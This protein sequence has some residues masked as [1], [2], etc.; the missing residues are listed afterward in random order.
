M[1]VAVE[2]C[3]LTFDRPRPSA[4]KKVYQFPAAMRERE[5]GAYWKCFQ[6]GH[7][8]KV[9]GIKLFYH[10]IPVY[11]SALKSCVIKSRAN[12]SIYI[13]INIYI[14]FNIYFRTTFWPADMINPLKPIQQIKLKR[15]V[16][17]KRQV[18]EDETKFP[19][20]NCESF[21]R[22]RKLQPKPRT[23]HRP[24]LCAQQ[25]CQI[26]AR[27]RGK[28]RQKAGGKFPCTY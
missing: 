27:I 24:G 13:Y 23:F 14:M 18:A 28:R 6:R 16:R 1:W 17:G 7:V 3:C 5:K 25:V 26:V 19:T 2:V 12:L 8:A 9:K 21:S 20:F 11:V 22:S 10:D 15:C 4:A